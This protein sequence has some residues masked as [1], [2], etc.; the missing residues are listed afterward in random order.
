MDPPHGFAYHANPSPPPP[1]PAPPPPSTPSSAQL[2]LLAG[3]QGV[4]VGTGFNAIWRP[5]LLSS[6][7]DRFLELNATRETLEFD[8]IGGRIP[9][10]GL[11]QRD[12][13]MTG[14]R[15]LQSIND[16]NIKPPDDGL[17]LEPGLWI[18][19]PATTDPTVSESIARLASIPHGTTILAQ[20]VASK[21]DGPPT[22]PPVS[23]NPFPVNATPPGPSPFPEQNLATETLFRSEKQDNINQDMVNDP[24]SVLRDVLKSQT[25]RSTITLQVSTNDLPVPGG[26]TGNTAFLVGGPHG[27]NANA[28]LVTATFWLETIAGSPDFQQLQYSQTVILNFNN[29][30]W[31]HVS[32]ATLTLSNPQDAH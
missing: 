18:N 26:G 23:L 32:V 1:A 29:L 20:G 3:L 4:W 5:N 14:L 30:S 12:I 16:T 28:V 21:A 11:L 24:N 6:G 31:P 15:Y 7:Q 17:H 25:V 22:I 19:I 2:G 8:P 10:R 9:N 13:E 27:P